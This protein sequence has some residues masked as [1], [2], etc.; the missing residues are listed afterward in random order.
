M[1]IYNMK[2][3]ST[4]FLY[5]SGKRGLFVTTILLLILVTSLAVSQET[6]EIEKVDDAYQ[7][8]ED[9]VDDCSSLTSEEKI[10]SLLAINKCKT[11]VIEDS[12]NTKECWPSSDCEIKTTAQAILALDNSNSDTEKAEDWLLSQNR[13]PTELNWYL[14]IENPGEATCSISYSDSSYNIR[15]GENKKISNSAGSCLALAQDNYWLRI[16]PSCYSEE[17]EVSC[18]ESFL[19][20]LLFKKKTSST[21]HVS[22][23]TS[24][25]AAGGTTREKV[26]SFCFEEDGSCDYEGSLWAALVLDSVGKDISSYLPYLIT[27]A[28]ENERYL[29][30]AF[31]YFLTPKTEYR[32]NILS[33]QKSNKWWEESGDKFYDTALALYPFQQ[34]SP[35][36]K[37]DSK[38]WL[39]DV[40]DADGCWERNTRNT[41]FILASIWPKTFGGEGEGEGEGGLPD[42]ENTG[43]CMSRANCEKA[44]G[45]IFADYDC[46]GAFNKCCSVQQIIETC[47]EMDGDVCA[48]NEACT[49]DEV[50]AAGTNYCCVDGFCEVVTTQEAS[51]CEINNGVC[52]AYGCDSNEE[53]AFYTCD[54]T[55]NTCCVLKTDD[56]SYWWI[57]VLLI[58]IILVIIGI[59][60]R[61]KLKVLLLRFKRKPKPRRP[62]DY[63][64]QGPTPPLIRPR[65][66]PRPIQ[67]RIL[68]PSRHTPAARPKRTKTSKELD[69]VLKKL[70][71]LGK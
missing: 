42:C 71:D 67:R 61:E 47:S 4:P 51:D 2:K 38:S 45:N 26:E 29:P 31:L 3:S 1:A 35:Q 50:S 46:P 70:K 56:R 52:R 9:R 64:R 34:E 66:R 32:K 44:G 30:E 33:K 27:L 65:P 22:E 68:P 14:E 18:D 20:T 49:G 25:A 11:D 40:Q 6:T 55:G 39:L 41:A 60:F 7:C 16:S 5:S 58:L 36:E 24:S 37:T 62:F 23:K 12:M 15:I 17:F 8:L 53:E 59:I 13:T 28:D 21:I 54:V 48:S 69:D 10:F 57:W 63:P 19:T 43:Y